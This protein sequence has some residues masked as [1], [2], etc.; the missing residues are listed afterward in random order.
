MIV[1]STT[2]LMLT[3]LNKGIIIQPIEAIF[4]FPDTVSIVG[5]EAITT[6]KH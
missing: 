4:D 2:L 3:K 6:N 1:T 5:S